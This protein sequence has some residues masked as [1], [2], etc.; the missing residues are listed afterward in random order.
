MIQSV[1][2]IYTCLKKSNY[3]HALPISGEIAYCKAN[4]R[5]MKYHGTLSYA[6]TDLRLPPTVG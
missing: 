3:F 6:F 1:H 4:L 5:G 2:K